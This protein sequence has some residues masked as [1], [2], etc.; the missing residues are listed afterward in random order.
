MTRF[1]RYLTADPRRAFFAIAWLALLAVSV[2]S[3]ISP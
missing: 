1:L 2:G 3:T